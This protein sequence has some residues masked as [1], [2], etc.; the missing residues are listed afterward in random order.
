MR[1]FIIVVVVDDGHVV[2][3]GWCLDVVSSPLSMSFRL[4]TKRPNEQMPFETMRV[5]ELWTMWC[6]SLEKLKGG[7]RGCD[8]SSSS[9]RVQVSGKR[10]IV[11][12]ESYKKDR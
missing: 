9:D 11:D 12:R 6:F 7:G 4:I 3:C 2:R 5:N 10:S 1:C 8:Y